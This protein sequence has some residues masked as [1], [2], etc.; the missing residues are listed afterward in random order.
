MHCL[1]EALF[2]VLVGD[3]TP[4]DP[5]KDV[6]EYPRIA[7]SV[8]LVGCYRDPTRG[9]RGK[10]MQVPLSGRETACG[11]CGTWSLLFSLHVHVFPTV[12]FKSWCAV[13]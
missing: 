1:H 12:I 13:I 11:S 4:R 7:K 9:I 8:N 6:N 3:V 2:Q 10:I 5:F